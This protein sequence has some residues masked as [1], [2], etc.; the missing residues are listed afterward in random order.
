LK[1]TPPKKKQMSEEVGTQKKSNGGFIAVI[2]LLLLGLSVMA[3]MF[4]KK[5][6]LLTDCSNKNKELNADMK[7]MNQMM[8]DFGFDV[9]GMSNDL[10]KDFSNMLKTY[11]ELIARD[12][13]KADSLNAQKDKINALIADLES[14]KK[15]GRLNAQK[16]AQMTRENTTLRSIM[17]GYV[18]QIDSLNTLNTKLHSDLDKTTTKLTSTTSERDQ[19]KA[20]AETNAEKVKTGQKLS[21]FNFSSVGLRM[22]FNNTTE[23]TKK[24][25]DCIQIQS[26]FTISENPLTNPGSKTVYLQITDP[27]GKIL[28]SKPNNTVQ[29]EQGTI[30][31]SDK[32]EIDYKNQRVDLSIFYDMPN[33]EAVKGNYKIK[34]YCEGLLIGNDSFTLK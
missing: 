28:Q 10:T 15:H 23:I 2:I 21:A 33:K 19:Y 34:I 5:N 24:A 1:I 25:K 27:D 13:S 18:I 30:A 12:A 16:I 22:K 7:G 26:S 14:A 31:F 8:V 32:K 9:D 3:Y 29:M 4:S 20:E 6:S 11:D 17:K